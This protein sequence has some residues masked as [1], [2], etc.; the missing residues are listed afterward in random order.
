MVVGAVRVMVEAAEFTPG[1]TDEGDS[2]QVGIGVGPVT[3]HESWIA[4]P[5]GTPFKGAI[6]ITSVIWPPGW[7]DKLVEAGCTEKS[8]GIVLKVAVTKLS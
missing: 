8:G 5:N 2:A 7:V 6:V 3:T 4:L 1:V